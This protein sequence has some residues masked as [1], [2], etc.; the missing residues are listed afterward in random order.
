M[1]GKRNT[2]PESSTKPEAPDAS[3]LTLGGAAL[4]HTDTAENLTITTNHE[5]HLVL[6]D[7]ETAAISAFRYGI[8]EELASKTASGIRVD[9]LLTAMTADKRIV[10]IIDQDVVD[11]THGHYN[12][13]TGLISSLA[14]GKELVTEDIDHND[15][16]VMRWRGDQ[17]TSIEIAS[18]E[19][20]Y[21][22]KPIAAGYDQTP[23]LIGIDDRET[24]L[25]TLGNDNRPVMP[26][27]R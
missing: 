21:V 8:R 10:S 2:V 7:D 25:F 16:R 5:N 17:G 1:F 23:I 3:L 4:H 14:A 18:G 27:T 19:T 26:S 9:V 22:P 12:V 15:E 6:T 13:R 20:I 24:P 11:G